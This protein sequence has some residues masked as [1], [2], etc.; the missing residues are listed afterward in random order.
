MGLETAEKTGSPSFSY[1]AGRT[2]GAARS[3]ETPRGARAPSAPPP[4]PPETSR[5]GPRGA[6]HVSV[7]HRSNSPATIAALKSSFASVRAST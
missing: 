5:A 1:S 2:C 3:A 6:P 7:K 4:E